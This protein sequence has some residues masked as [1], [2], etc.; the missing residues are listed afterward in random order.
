MCRQRA[1]RPNL[2][3][4]LTKWLRGPSELEFL[5]VLRDLHAAEPL[6]EPPRPRVVLLDA[7][8]E[9]NSGRFRLRLEVLDDRGTDPVAL[10]VG[11]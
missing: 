5:L 2:S 11:Q 3:Q 8:V 10:N 4:T 6:V 1:S 7:N 9:A